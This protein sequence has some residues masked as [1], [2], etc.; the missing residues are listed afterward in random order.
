MKAAIIGS[1]Y[2]RHKIFSTKKSYEGTFSC[3]Y[4]IIITILIILAFWK[5]CEFPN[6]SNFN[7]VYF[8]KLVCSVIVI[9]L[10][11][12]FTDQIDNLILPLIF[13]R[14]LLLF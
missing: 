13:Y 6:T 7:I 3:L 1:K 10:L 14:L 11:E 4:S 12:A 2:G 8:F 9:S 5:F